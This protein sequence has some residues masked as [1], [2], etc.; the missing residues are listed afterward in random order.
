MSTYGTMKTRIA[1]ELKR[2]DIASTSTVISDAILSAVDHYEKEP[3]WFNEATTTVTTSSGT[4][5]YALPT[6]FVSEESLILTVTSTRTYQLDKT[7]YKQIEKI[8]QS[9]YQGYPVEY[10]IFDEKWRF[11]PTPNGTYTVTISYIQRLTTLSADGDSNAW[12]TLGEELIR[13]RAKVDIYENT[14]RNFKSAERMR[15]RELEAYDRL[16]DEN[17]TKL[18]SGRISKTYF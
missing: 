2:G 9:T 1:N 8:D 16:R 4:S 17:V 10:A 15:I 5:T 12:T 6:D 7:S 11:Y 13:S 3:F 18:S 14:I